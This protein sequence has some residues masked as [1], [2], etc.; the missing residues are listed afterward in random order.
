LPHAGFSVTT[1]RHFERGGC[2]TQGATHVRL[3][4]IDGHPRVVMQALR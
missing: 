3:N 4:V 2:A 1:L